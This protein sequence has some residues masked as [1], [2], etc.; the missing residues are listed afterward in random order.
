MQIKHTS[1]YTDKIHLQ[2]FVLISEHVMLCFRRCELFPEQFILNGSLSDFWFSVC[3]VL[4]LGGIS[5][6]F[7]VQ[8][9]AP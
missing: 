7:V 1:I 2:P 8:Y 5:K 9:L 4:L 3:S 6:R